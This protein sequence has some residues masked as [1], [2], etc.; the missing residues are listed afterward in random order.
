MYHHAFM[1]AYDLV[2]REIQILPFAYLKFMS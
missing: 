1:F 2:I